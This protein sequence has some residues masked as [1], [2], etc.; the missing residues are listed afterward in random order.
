MRVPRFWP[1]GVFACSVALSI[2]VACSSEDE[3]GRAHAPQRQHADFVARVE[4]GEDVQ[5]VADRVVLPVDPELRGVSLAIDEEGER[6][7]VFVES[8]SSSKLTALRDRIASTKGVAE[9]DGPLG[10]S[11]PTECGAF[12]VVE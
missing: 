6:L 7:C 2:A 5:R 10:E 3:P 8:G 11:G 1:G 9:V 4:P 12:G